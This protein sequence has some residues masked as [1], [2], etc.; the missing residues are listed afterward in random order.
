M[1]THHRL[2]SLQIRDA[3]GYA[4]YR[5]EMAP[6]L[7]AAG[8]RFLLDMTGEATVHPA[9]FPPDRV[10][11]IAFPSDQAAAGFFADPAY[12]AIRSRW[13]APSVARTHAL[14]LT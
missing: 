1:P 14:H 5:A 9:G 6:L 13:F 12:Q 2:V 10:L 3:E 11:L 8:G 4:R 7:A